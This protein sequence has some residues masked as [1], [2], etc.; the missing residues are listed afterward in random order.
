MREMSKTG[1]DSMFANGRRFR[2][3]QGTRR[4]LVDVIIVDVLIGYILLDISPLVITPIMVRAPFM[5]G[6]LLSVLTI[7]TDP[8]RLCP[9][10]FSPALTAAIVCVRPAAIVRQ[11]RHCSKHVTPVA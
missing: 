7:A 10:A 9:L 8:S 5:R 4:P 3:R 1:D 11:N 6:R 2:R